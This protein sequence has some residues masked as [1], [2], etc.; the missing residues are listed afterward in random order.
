MLKNFSLLS[1][2]TT[3][4]LLRFK[5]STLDLSLYKFNCLYN[6]S[7][8]CFSQSKKYPDLCLI[9]KKSKR[10][11]PWGLK[12]AEKQLLSSETFSILF[13]IIFELY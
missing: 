3:N 6:S 5:I 8:F 13:V 1:T 12:R 10:Y 2:A 9:T 7:K 4:S 11:F